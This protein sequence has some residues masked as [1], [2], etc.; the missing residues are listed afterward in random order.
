MDT[1][2]ILDT[3]HEFQGHMW[4]DRINEKLAD[5]SLRRWVS[6]FHPDNILCYL[7][8]DLYYGA[9]NAGM[10]MVFS[11]GTSWMLR[12]PR[13]GMICDD[14]A[15]EKVAAEVTTLR[16]LHNKTTI[17]VPKVQAWGPAARN[18][19]GLGPFIMM[20][21]I[22]GVSLNRHLKDYSNSDSP[23]RLMREDIS[24]S[25]IEIIYR[26]MANFLLQIF[27]LDFD[28]I[29]SLP[30]PEDGPQ[31]SPPKRPLTFKAHTILQDGGVN[32]FGTDWSPFLSFFFPFI[33]FLLVQLS[34]LTKAIVPGDRSRGF[35]TTTE[36]FQYIVSQDWE[37]LI[38]QPNSIIGPHD[39][40]NK[41][42]AFKALKAV[43]GDL[44]N[45]KYDRGK[46]KLICDD[47]G[48]ANLIVRSSEDL[49]VVGVVDLEWSYIGPAQLFGSAPWWL[50]QER[51]V[52]PEWDCNA[53]DEPPPKITAR[54]FK[55][56]DIF[57]RVLEEEESHMPG[58]EEKELSSLVK[59]SQ[60][61][62]AMWLHMLLSVG[63]NDT[64]SFPFTHLRRHLGISEWEAREGKFYNEQE[65]EEFAAKKVKEMKE[66]D[67][68]LEKLEKEKEL[69]D[70]GNMEMGEFVAKAT[71]GLSSYSSL[72]VVSNDP[73]D[74]KGL[75][76]S[77]AP[78]D[79]EL[80]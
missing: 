33:I 73:K 35:E 67:V 40:K 4:V 23:S 74:G 77:V 28:H 42:V 59:W 49:T 16:L 25:D 27:E 37:Q 31:R 57:M 26:Q 2:A 30:W 78:L 68:A 48:L 43:V 64:L 61:S 5:G 17:P 3:V 38:H 7:E 22:N 11:D 9:F 52:N 62:G 75:F 8:G 36:Y 54:Y 20:D 46:F 34:V 58:H 44:V 66:Y 45:K 60:A 72:N 71:M 39:A 50:L 79:S 51:P 80:V 29:G 14:Y 56:L 12:F 32:T 47:L 1:N 21:F 63:F 10:K 69:V 15:D 41:Y 19:L 18:P 6:S 55:H 53:D 76:H 13:V 24:D 65:L 70:S